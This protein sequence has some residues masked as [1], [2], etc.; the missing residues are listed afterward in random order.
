VA[1]LPGTVSNFAMSVLALTKLPLSEQ[2]KAVETGL[3]SGTLTALA[4]NLGISKTRIIDGLK[5]VQRTVTE[6]EKNHERFSPMESERLFRV[7]RVHARA[8]NIFSTDHAVAEWMN[9]PDD[10]L[11]GKAPLE[12]L[13]TDLGAQKVEALLDG[14]M[15]GVPR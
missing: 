8:R 2:I 6:R 12:M 1:Y 10:F 14:M 9:E 11:S 15:H 13:T 7:A 3:P 4:R 5:L